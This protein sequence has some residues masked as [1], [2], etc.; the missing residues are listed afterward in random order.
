MQFTQRPELKTFYQSYIDALKAAGATLIDV[1]F[2]PDYSKIAAFRTDVLL[3][4][5]KTDLNKYLA[6]RG[7][8]YRTLEDLI[9][10]N[11]ENKDRELPLFGQELFVQSQQK[12]AL[13]DKA[14]TDALQTIKKATQEDGIDAVIAKDNL[15]GLVGP[16]SG[17]S[18]SI[19]AV[20][21]YPYITVPVGLREN[22]AVGMSF[23][24]KAFSEPALIR[25]AYAFEQKTKGRAVPQLL[26]SYPKKT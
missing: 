3:Y 21:G 22:T 1:T 11:E 23:F 2:A 19:A 10:F 4:E 6:G 14:Y 25:Y 12:G 9:K 20:A 8:K 16:T 24:G 15:D 5:F 18:W 7:A 26:P 13:S 17:A